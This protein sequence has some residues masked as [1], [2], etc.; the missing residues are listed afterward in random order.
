[1]ARPDSSSV[2]GSNIVSENGVMFVLAHMHSHTLSMRLALMFY[3]LKRTEACFH[4]I[5]LCLCLWG[6]YP[7]METVETLIPGSVLPNK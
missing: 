7:S 6:E 4:K 1:M 2:L 5:I 3:V